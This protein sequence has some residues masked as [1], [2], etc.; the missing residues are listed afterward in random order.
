MCRNILAD[1]NSNGIAD[2]AELFSIWSKPDVT[3]SDIS[4]MFA[5]CT[6][7]FSFDG[8]NRVSKKF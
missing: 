1:S 3:V 4:D 2:V 8:G 5:D 6:S 7:R